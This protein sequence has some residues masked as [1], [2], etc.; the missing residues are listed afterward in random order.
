MV[1]RSG[2]IREKGSQELREPP[3]YFSVYA[4][5]YFHT[6]FSVESEKGP[7]FHNHVGFNF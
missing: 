6:L 5:E 2:R 1:G 7:A 3:W 4:K